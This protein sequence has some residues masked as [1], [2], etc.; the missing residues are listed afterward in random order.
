[1]GGPE[2]VTVDA[3]PD[4]FAR[5]KHPHFT[6]EVAG[7]PMGF[8]ARAQ[9]RVRVEGAGPRTLNG[10]IP[11]SFVT[12]RVRLGTTFASGDLL[13]VTAEIQDVRTWGEELPLA[14]KPADVTLFGYA[15]PS[16]DLHQGFAQ[17]AVEG[18][19]VRV[20]R[21][22]ISLD[23]QR[24]VGAVDWTMQ[25][26]SFDGVR[27]QLALGGHTLDAF[28]VVLRE[29][30]ASTDTLA[31]P[32]AALLGAHYEWGWQK[33]VRVAPLV[34]A[35]ATTDTGRVRW[36]TGGRA[37]G[38][39]F[40]ITYD[41]E[42]YYQGA[43]IDAQ[44]STAFLGAVSGGYAWDGPLKPAGRIFLDVVSG[45]S[46]TVGTAAFDTLFAT[47]HKFY[48]FQDLFL[49]LPLHT[50]GRGLVDVGATGGFVEGPLYGKAFVHVFG[51]AD[52]DPSRAWLYGV[53]PD[54][55]AGY[56]HPR[57]LKLEVGASLFIPIGPGLGR[58]SVPT[59]WLYMALG[60][61]I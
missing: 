22:E 61:E 49:N 1:M 13:Q 40:G 28:G 36:T 32:D 59:P 6:T 56:T 38:N 54:V 34:L 9:A 35:D 53:E 4:P 29:A 25:G 44:L 16:L 12:H 39:V 46:T 17:V 30:D 42:A 37:D 7:V 21:Q 26:R 57:G 24:L 20:G 31:V 33:Y 19:T 2:R 23:G 11:E 15:A 14:G 45:N 8:E 5:S 43:L 51:A 18:F 47:N 10:G 55:V 60:A 52:A 27:A 48:G 50:G 41:V 58:G 3:P